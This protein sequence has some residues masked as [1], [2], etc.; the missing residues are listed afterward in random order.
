MPFVPVVIPSGRYRK[1]E[2]SYSTRS[3]GGIEY[4]CLRFSPFLLE[5][6]HWR[7]F[8][9]IALAAD[10]DSRRVALTEAERSNPDARA[11]GHEGG[12]Q[13]SLRLP[14]VGSLAELFPRS[15]TRQMV[16]V[17][18]AEPGRLVLALRNLSASN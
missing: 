18:E 4:I 16:P 8:N 7:R 3:R 1:P 15:D 9:R 10:W 11:L 17:V 12:R 6:L 2:C 5:K 14:R 13:L